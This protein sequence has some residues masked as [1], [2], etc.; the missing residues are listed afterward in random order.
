[1]GAALSDVSKDWARLWMLVGAYAIL[2]IVAA[3]ITAGRASD[4]R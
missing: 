2:A 4:G 3:R 1:M